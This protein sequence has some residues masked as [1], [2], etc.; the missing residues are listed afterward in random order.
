MSERI[1]G[2]KIWIEQPGRL[3]TIAIEDNCPNCGVTAIDTI[4]N[5]DIATPKD[6]KFKSWFE[7]SS[8][9]TEWAV[10]VVVDISVTTDQKVWEK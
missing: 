6:L 10:D 8:C 1:P 2:S 4:E 3:P 7:C 5:Y 9:D